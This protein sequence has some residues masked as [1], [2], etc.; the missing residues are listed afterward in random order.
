VSHHPERESSQSAWE[1]ARK[2]VIEEI[3]EI[4]DA[5]VRGRHPETG[6]NSHQGSE[7]HWLELQFGVA[8]NAKNIPD[9]KGFEIKDDT[10]SKTTF[11]DWTADHYI[12]FSHEQCRKNRNK[13]ERCKKCSAAR[14]S[15]DEF[16]DIFG[17]PNPLKNNRPSWSGRVFPKVGGANERGQEM[18]VA[19]DGTIRATYSFSCDHS[20]DR[21]SRVPP[22]LQIENLVIAEWSS[23]SLQR[24]VTNK[25]GGFGWFKCIQE[26]SGHGKYIGIQFGRPIR[27]S[28]WIG[29]VRE[30]AIYL[31]SGMY[32]GNNRPY[33]NW[34]ADN[35]IWTRFADEHYG[36]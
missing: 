30:S 19:A 24:R 21:L 14:I 17:A 8:R 9:F 18:V 28:D 26:D 23:D 6:P 13:A 4:F 7:G 20:A 33:S 29:L 25:F 15:R 27:F 34:R 12:F 31:D 16:F 32:K 2:E 11:G 35:R 1:R 10:A 5:K 22:D 3:K 36:D